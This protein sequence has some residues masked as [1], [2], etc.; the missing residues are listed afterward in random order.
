MKFQDGDILGSAFSRLFLDRPEFIAPISWLFARLGH[1][2][3]N[4]SLYN[5]GGLLFLTIDVAITYALIYGLNQ[6][7]NKLNQNPLFWLE[8]VAYWLISFTAIRW[9]FKEF[10]EA[11]SLAQI[12]EAY[13]NYIGPGEILRFSSFWLNF[14]FVFTLAF[15]WVR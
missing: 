5:L 15:Y 6:I 1:L 11:E 8:P 13:Y 7:W 12:V 3:S 2:L 14:V 10:F 9:F 4:L